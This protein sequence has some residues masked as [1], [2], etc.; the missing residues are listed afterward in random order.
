MLDGVLPT[1]MAVKAPLAKACMLPGRPR[2]GRR[3]CC[4]SRCS[5]SNLTMVIFAFVPGVDPND[6]DLQIHRGLLS[7]SG[8]RRPVR[9]ADEGNWLRVCQRAFFRTLQAYCEPQR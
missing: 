2:P 7:I 3:T 4:S 1:L 6:L 8:E 9:I 5:L